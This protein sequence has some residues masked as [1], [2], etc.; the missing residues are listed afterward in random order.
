[1]IM[2]CCLDTSTFN[3]SLQTALDIV[4]LDPEILKVAEDWFGFSQS[5]GRRVHLADGVKFV[6]DSV[7]AGKK[8]KPCIMR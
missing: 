2:L 5:E 1:M 8:S 6:E 3:Y 4:E 7:L